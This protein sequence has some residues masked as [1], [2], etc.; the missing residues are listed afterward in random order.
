MK[1]E[2]RTNDGDTTYVDC[3]WVEPKMDWISFKMSDTANS[4]VT[5]AIVKAE[6][7][8]SVRLVVEE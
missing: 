8:V 6:N 7:V 4:I 1:Y 2:V 3:E 5:V